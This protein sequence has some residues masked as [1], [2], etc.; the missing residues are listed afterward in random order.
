MEIAIIGAGITG[1]TTALSLHKMGFTATVYEKASVLNEIG[2]GVL[3]QPNAMKVMKWL[4]LADKIAQEGCKLNSMQ[5]G[6][7]NLKP[8]K[9]IDPSMLSTLEGINTIAIHRGKLQRI[10]FDAFTKVGR[11]ELG[12]AYV[13]SHK[14]DNQLN[15]I[16]ENG[17]AETDILLGADG[18]RSQVRESIGL[19][20]SYRMTNQV[21]WRG[22]SEM[23]LPDH[24]Q[25]E[26]MELWGKKRRFGFSQLSDT[27][28]YFFAVISK[29]LCP[30]DFKSIDLAPFYK[31]FNPIVIDM[32]EH[33][34][35]MHVT[36]MY[37]IKRLSTWHNGLDTC[38]LGDAAHATTP[39]MGQG[40]C[41]GIEDG[42]YFSQS[43]AVNQDVK[44]CF[45][46]FETKRRKKVDYVVN[47]SW[48]FGKMVH[49]PLGQAVL[50]SIMKVT[51]AKTM[52]S[53]MTQLY[54]VEI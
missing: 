37:D 45:S 31:D 47:N 2:A 18:I 32:I 1:L 24:L 13:S 16:F 27:S 29:E 41:Q 17:T 33:A 19:G 36:E 51:P 42:Y 53:Q 9:P 49:N 46:A 7:P 5:I 34:G 54:D 11:V 23:Q 38:L 3:L 20:S 50:K 12:K 48:R 25:N 35:S 6:L 30:M 22:V 28:V 40:A 4:G 14:L 10:L 26:S 43:F 52:V 39:N 8:I 21:C 44:T 15:I